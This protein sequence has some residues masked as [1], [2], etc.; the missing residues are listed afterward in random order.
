[1]DFSI[2]PDSRWIAYASQD[3]DFNSEVWLMPLDKSQPPTNVSR[4]PDND[5]NPVFSPDGKIL[6]FTGRRVAE[7]NDI[8]YVYLQEENDEKTV[9]DRKLEKAIEAMKKRKSSDKPASAD[10]KEKADSSEDGAKPADKPAED[11]K[12]EKKETAADSKSAF[13]I[14]LDKIH[15]GLVVRW[16]RAGE[17]LKLLNGNTVDLDS[18]V[19]VIADEHAVES[20]AGIMGG[21]ATAVGDG[22]ANIYVEAAFWWPEA[23]QGREPIR[24]RPAD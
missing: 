2:S 18:K 4:H 6:A 11:K 13:K 5:G 1:L 10:K 12:E 15:G 19:G 24:T 21:D 23:V 7:E 22:T 8:Y 14:D 3:D 9:R 17:Q 20:L 16:G